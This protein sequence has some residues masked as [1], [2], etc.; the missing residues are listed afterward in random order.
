MSWHHA[1]PG[2]K[3]RRAPQLATAAVAAII[4][5]ALGACTSTPSASTTGSPVSALA[6][7]G[8]G[9]HGRAPL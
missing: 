9:D 2:A 7:A 6:T 5:L 1:Q 4:L 8:R 3:L